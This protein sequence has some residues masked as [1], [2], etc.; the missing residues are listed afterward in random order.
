[1]MATTARLTEPIKIF[2]SYAHEDEELENELED[3]L[4]NLRN[5]GI[6]SYWDDREIRGGKEW[7]PKIMSHLNSAQIILLL[8]S[9][10]FMASHYCCEMELKLAMERHKP[11]EARVIP[12]ILR[13]VDWEGAPFSEL[14]VFPTDAKPVDSTSWKNQNEAFLDVVKG[15][16]KVI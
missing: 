15:L 16:R 7:H 9:P 5:Q 4:A 6:I 13:P 11:G 1:L 3:H 2:F 12:I 10:D 14:Q 8:V